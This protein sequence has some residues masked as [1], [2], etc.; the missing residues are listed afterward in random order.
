MDY[1]IELI[2]ELWTK[3]KSYMPAKERQTAADHFL[4]T[5]VNNGVDPLL[6]RE[7]FLD[8][9]DYLLK[10]FQEYEEENTDIDY[11]IDDE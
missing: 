7:E 9:C 10:S 4:S 3:M 8:G 11:L 2:L 6:H 1:D 5:L